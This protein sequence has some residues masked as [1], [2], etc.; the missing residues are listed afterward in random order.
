MWKRGT[1]AQ[2]PCEAEM[3][4]DQLAC[5]GIQHK[6]CKC[7]C[8]RC[9]RYVCWSYTES[10]AMLDA[11]TPLG[12][13]HCSDPRFG[14]ASMQGDVLH[15]RASCLPLALSLPT[16][17]FAIYCSL[18][19]AALFLAESILSALW[20]HFHPLAPYKPNLISLIF[21]GYSFLSSAFYCGG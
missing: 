12:R 5:L 1:H 20:L 19:V 3:S 18:L 7:R 9:L 15:P 16:A 13:M 11:L 4:L 14:A 2:R 10:P 8:K 17:V 6:V 21:S